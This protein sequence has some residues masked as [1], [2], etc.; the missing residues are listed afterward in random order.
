MSFFDRAKQ[1]AGQAATKAKEELDDAQTRRELGQAYDA[2][3][4]LAFELVTSGDLT[5]E[6]LNAEVERIKTLKAKLEE[7][8]EAAS[9]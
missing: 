6:R 2:L 9:E 3:G 7:K 1:V 4:K 5:D 8:T